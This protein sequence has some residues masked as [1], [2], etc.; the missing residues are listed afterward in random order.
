[1]NALHQN[2]TCP[3]LHSQLTYRCKRPWLVQGKVRGYKLLTDHHV[4]ARVHRVA[5]SRRRKPTEEETEQGS[6]FRK[7]TKKTENVERET[8][9]AGVKNGLDTLAGD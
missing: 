5:Y 3:R 9:R 7:C 2:T 8:E 4:K 1:M 6:T